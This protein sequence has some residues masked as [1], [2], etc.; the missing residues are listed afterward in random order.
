MGPAVYLLGVNPVEL[1]SFPPA[2]A[3]QSLICVLGLGVQRAK[4]SI[5]LPGQELK[6]AWQAKRELTCLPASPSLTSSALERNGENSSCLSFFCVSEMPVN[7]LKLGDALNSL[8]QLQDCSVFIKIIHKIHGTEEEQ[9]IL[10]QKMPDRVAYVVSFLEKSCKHKSTP[11]SLVSEEKLLAADELELAKVVMLLLYYASMSDKIPREWTT[12]EYDLQ[13]EMA[14]F[15]NFML[16]NEDC[17]G[18]NLEIFLQ[19]KMPQSSSISSTSVE[20]TTP[21]KREVHFL[22][23]QKVASSSSINKMLPG[24][25][26]SPIGDVMQTPQFQMRRLKK[27]LEAERENRDELEHELAEN[28]K[29][30][31]EKGEGA[32][33]VNFS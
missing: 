18:E 30:I 22:K 12:V 20:E 13:A 25:S 4:P 11:Q 24:S 19:K 23:L 2:S 31:D 1:E 21:P 6:S 27:L 14:K 3:G 28:R 10:Q 26:T 33:P 17:L 29:L 8:S 15:L 7:S 9:T 32:T 5:D 16:Y